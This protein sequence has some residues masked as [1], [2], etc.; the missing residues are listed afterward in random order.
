MMMLS[1]QPVLMMMMMMMILNNLDE[2]FPEKGSDD[3]DR[4]DL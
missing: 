1:C 4:D 2:G 3:Q